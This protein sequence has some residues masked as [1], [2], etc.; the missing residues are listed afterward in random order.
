[1]RN[2]KFMAAIPMVATILLPMTTFAED[3]IPSATTQGNIQ[4]EEPYS[5]TQD[6][7][8][9]DGV[10]KETIVTYQQASTYTVT[11]PKSVTLESSK[12]ATYDIKVTGDISSDKKVTVTPIDDD[13]S[14]DG[15]NFKMSD[16]SV[17]SSKKDDVWVD[18]TQDSTTWTSS[19]IDEAGETGVTKSGTIDGSD[20][21]T[22]GSWS[23]SLTFKI[24]LENA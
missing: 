15:I 6:D 22:S 2:S 5:I 18:V 10:T 8:E 21:L 3:E 23:G 4:D 7:M 13:A 14:K 1:M 9:K 19:E 24:A 16:T 20:V 11:I 12:Q 17:S